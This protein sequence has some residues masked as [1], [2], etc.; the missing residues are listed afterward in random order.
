[1]IDKA[2][3][4]I[5]YSANF[6]P[7][8]KF[9]PN[10]VRFA[11]MCSSVKK[12]QYYEGTCDLRPLGQDAILHAYFKRRGARNHKLEILESGKKTLE[13]IGEIITSVFD[14][15]PGRMALM[16]IDCAADMFG[17]PLLH[18]HR[19]LRV[20]FKRSSNECGELDY[21]LIGGR[22]LEYFRYGKSPNCVRTYDK[23]AEC[24]SR[25][26]EILKHSNP[27]AEPPS[28]SDIFGFPED[29]VMTRVERQIGGGRVPQEVATFRHLYRATEFNPF[30]QLCIVPGEFTLPD[31]RQYGD[32]RS[33]KLAGIHT[34]VDTYG[35]Q[36]TRAMLNIHGNAKRLMEDYDAYRA[37]TKSLRDLSVEAIVETYRS[38]VSK[39]VKGA[40][41][42]PNRTLA[43]RSKEALLSS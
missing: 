28:F 30:T 38:S 10:E 41:F 25:L 3:F 39:Q 24:K 36:A 26:R 12:S 19:A 11:G 33:L 4:R 14:V 21:D 8:F 43:E 31:P 6:R 9:L 20:K 2:E 15:D 13:E 34:Y 22:R 23:P 35:Y 32:A 7:D 27:E 17:I 16:R 37:E 42:G 5:P 18:L 29:T 1:M 40:K